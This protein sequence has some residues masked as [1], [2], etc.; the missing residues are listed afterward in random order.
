MQ[1]LWPGTINSLTAEEGFAPGYPDLF[2]FLP[3]SRKHQLPPHDL[4]LQ[5]KEESQRG[6]EMGQAEIAVGIR[7]GHMGIQG[8]ALPAFY[9]L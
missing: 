7:C 1:G 9:I 4:G 2:I 3:S 5:I 8:S 6:K